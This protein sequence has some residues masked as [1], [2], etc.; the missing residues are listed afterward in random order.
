MLTMGGSA[1]AEARTV[2][3]DLSTEYPIG[4]T[5][6]P[7]GV[8]LGIAIGG[9]LLLFTILVTIGIVHVKRKHRRQQNETEEATEDGNVDIDLKTA[10]RSTRPPN[11]SIVQRSSFNPFLPLSEQQLRDEWDRYDALQKAYLERSKSPGGF[12]RNSSLSLRD[13][14]PLMSNNSE[15]HSPEQTKVVLSPV[16]PPGYVVPDPRWPTRGSSLMKRKNSQDR[17]K[18][19]SPTKDPYP[20]DIMPYR[21]IHRRST[22]ENQLSTILRSTSQRLKATQRQSMNRTLTTLGR[23]PGLPPTERLPTPPMR[24]TPGNR[25]TLV[26]EE[27][28]GSVGSSIGSIFDIYAQTPSPK[29]KH[30]RKFSKQSPVG[31]LSPPESVDSPDSLCISKSPD[32]VLPAPLTSRSRSPSRS[33]RNVLT[34]QPGSDARDNPPQIYEDLD[35]TFFARD[36]EE[37]KEDIKILSSPHCASLSGDP[38]YS[39]VKSSKPM[40]PSPRSQVSRPMHSR[41]ATFGQEATPDRPASFYSPLR[42]VSG[43][44][45]SPSKREL[46]E[47]PTTTEPN[48]FQWQPSE[49]NQ[50]R[51]TP[52]NPKT[53]SNRRKGHKR[54]NVIRMSGFSRPT[55]TVE[56]VPEEAAE[57]STVEFNVPRH[58]PSLRAEVPQEFSPTRLL[59]SRKTTQRPPSTATFNPNLII[60]AISSWSEDDSPTLGADTPRETGYS[61]TLSICNYYAV[62]D[63]NP[64]EDFLKPGISRSF[65]PS[66]S[67]IKSRRHGRNYSADIAFFPT[68]QFQQFLQERLLSFPPRPT[69]ASPANVAP[70]AILTSTPTSQALS[71][72]TSTMSGF[73]SSAATPALPILTVPSHLTGPRSEPPKHTTA[74]L[75]PPPCTESML[76]T[77]SMLRR[78]NSQVSTLSS[79]SH[80]NMDSSTQLAESSR[81]PAPK[82]ISRGL[83]VN[84][85]EENDKEFDPLNQEIDASPEERGRSRGSQHYLSLGQVSPSKSALYRAREKSTV[86]NSKNTRPRP[87]RIDSHRIHKE[88]KKRRTEEMNGGGMI[89]ELEI[90]QESPGSSPPTGANKVLVVGNGSGNGNGSI[91]NNGLKFP[92]L[93]SEGSVGAT[94]PRDGARLSALRLVTPDSQD[95][96]L[97]NTNTNTNLKTTTT[98]SNSIFL[99]TITSDDPHFLAS[100]KDT[101]TL[102]TNIL[103]SKTD[104][105]KT[106]SSTPPRWSDAMTKATMTST[107]HESKMEHPSPLTP[108]KWTPSSNG[109]ATSGLGVAG[110]RLLDKDG[111]VDRGCRLSL[112]FYDQDG[113]LKASPERERL[114]AERMKEERRREGNV[115]GGREERFSAFVM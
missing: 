104:N 110:V 94:P 15:G 45:Q 59:S 31:L 53:M 29:K 48:P 87:E 100:P 74:T 77:I 83:D 75:S 47:L 40:T 103:N 4:A 18:S 82:D 33:A 23:S 39:S 105:S 98:S 52:S 7:L 19:A 63:F 50:T 51:A 79:T 10:L 12:Y 101:L 14:W 38:F 115:R 41:K 72:T 3:R 46:P 86:R 25:E 64:E 65:Q 16:A 28:V 21:K 93:S 43:N 88:R 85:I 90:V 11:V 26:D 5:T 58:S 30:L 32:V 71:N 80:A 61:P 112:G 107:R 111:L 89:D 108:P 99:Q 67:V 9:A 70:T 73:H 109:A 13:S 91:G 76:S 6:L 56:I 24:K 114:L 78:M 60:P 35:L 69:E 95:T 34:N 97:L 92:T 20:M 68:P 62:K 37:S 106:N 113:F 27:N 8:I 54:S 102:T 22:S 49:A 42:T 81:S 57:A 2:R 44:V 1:M 84:I 55:S 36:P 66:P 17:S 96:S